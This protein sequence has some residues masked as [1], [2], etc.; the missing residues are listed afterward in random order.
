MRPNLGT[1]L[2]VVLSRRKWGCRPG[3]VS[4]PAFGLQR[5]AETGYDPRQDA[6]SDGHPLSGRRLAPLT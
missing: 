1:A 4:D 5:F 3:L 6:S 2:F